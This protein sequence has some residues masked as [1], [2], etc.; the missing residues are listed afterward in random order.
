VVLNR[1]I[2]DLPKILE[3]PG[4]QVDIVLADSDYVYIPARPSGVQIIGS[5]AANGTIS[6]VDNKKM[7]YYI[8]QAGGFTPDA[9]KNEIRLVKPNGKVYYGGQ[10]ASHKITLGDAIVVPSR[11][12][13]R[14]PTGR[15]LLAPRRQSLVLCNH[16]IYSRQAEIKRFMVE[17]L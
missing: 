4:G 15:K 17:Y 7:K 16:D 12:I 3:N 6:Y 13:N 14:K 9:D 8:E 2:I 10:A 1:I 11:Y 5:V